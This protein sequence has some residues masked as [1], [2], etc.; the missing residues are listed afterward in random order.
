M[1]GITGVDTNSSAYQNGKI[2]GTV[3]AVA[4]AFVDPCALGPVAYFALQSILAAQVFGASFSLANN[5]ASGNW[6]GAAFDALS[7]FGSAAQFLQACFAA[8]TPIRTPEGAVAIEHIKPGDVVLSRSEFDPTGPVEAKV[9]EEVFV[10][11]APVLHLRVGGRTITTTGEHPFFAEG[12]GWVAAKQLE[13]GE[14]VLGLSDE[15]LLVEGVDD[16]GLVT[17]VYNFRV[18][19]WHTYFVGDSSWGFSVWAHNAACLPITGRPAHG[20]PVHNSTMVS[21]ALA[22]S[23]VPGVT[24]VRTNQALVDAAGQTV[25]L[26]RPDVQ[27][28]Q[29]GLVHIIEVNVS[30]GAGYHAAREAQLRSLLGSLFGSYTGL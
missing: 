1:V 4:L 13:P 21:E 28:V 18:A 11:T 12:R 6:L 14:R 30:R 9:V 27:Y 20:G 3:A 15:W 16:A 19:D 8:G 7:I 10:R 17:T 5:V 22:V 26:L 2:L 25:S 29:G 23:A 24:G